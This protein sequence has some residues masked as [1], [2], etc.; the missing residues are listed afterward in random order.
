MLQLYCK[1]TQTTKEF[2]VGTTLLETLP[3][4][5]FDRPFPIVSAKVNNVSQGL[6]FRVHNSCDVEF[7]DVREHSAMLVYCR[8]LCFCNIIGA[9]L[10]I[11]TKL[12]KLH[13]NHLFHPTARNRLP[14]KMNLR[15]FQLNN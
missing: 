4:F 3:E 15:S 14:L 10:W 12:S 8:S 9:S 1:N 6:K 7:L 2:Q 5:Q 11:F 13:Q